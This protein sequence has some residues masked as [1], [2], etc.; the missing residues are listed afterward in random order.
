MLATDWLLFLLSV[1]NFYN[2]A[3][4]RSFSKHRLFYLQNYKLYLAA[5]LITNFFV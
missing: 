4:R 5:T 2:N 1:F 3:Y